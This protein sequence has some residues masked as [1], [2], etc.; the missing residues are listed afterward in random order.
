M[1]FGLWSLAYG[2]WLP[3]LVLVLGLGLGLGFG[4]GLGLG[5]GLVVILWL[6]CGV[7]FP[8]PNCVLIDGLSFPSF[9]PP[10]TKFKTWTAKGEI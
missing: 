8:M 1:V 7:V 6:F 2:L 9:H 3:G 4:L 5:L 10:S